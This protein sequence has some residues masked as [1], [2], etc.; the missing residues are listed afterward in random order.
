MFRAVVFYSLIALFVYI[1]ASDQSNEL[2]R[3]ANGEVSET[4]RENNV[5]KA[6]GWPYYLGK[7]FSSN[8]A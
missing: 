5:A 3:S 4:Q 1:G 6:L 7:S 8:G 2:V